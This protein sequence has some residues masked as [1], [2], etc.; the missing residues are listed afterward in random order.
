MYSSSASRDTTA[1]NSLFF[2][3]FSL[4]LTD[5]FVSASL[6]RRRHAEQC[7]EAPKQIHFELWKSSSGKWGIINN[8]CGKINT[9]K[10]CGKD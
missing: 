8:L 6:V 1:R 4:E 10:R 7:R 3:S 5:V 9:V 2:V